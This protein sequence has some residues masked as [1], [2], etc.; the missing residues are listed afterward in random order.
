M[1]TVVNGALLKPLPFAE[2][3]RLVILSHWTAEPGPNA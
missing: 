3:D 1:F 2:P